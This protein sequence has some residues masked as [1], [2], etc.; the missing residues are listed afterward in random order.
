MPC[1]TWK[2]LSH[3]QAETG[4]SVSIRPHRDSVSKLNMGNEPAKLAKCD[5][6]DNVMGT[7]CT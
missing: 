4:A 6:P 5:C 2:T 7:V 3:L 1:R